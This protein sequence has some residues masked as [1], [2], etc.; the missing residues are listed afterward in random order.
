M[1]L[2]RRLS[3]CRRMNKQV[4]KSEKRQTLPLQ[5]SRVLRLPH[6]F[7][8]TG[9]QKQTKRS[10]GS[11]C[12]GPATN[13]SFRRRCVHDGLGNFD[14][15]CGANFVVIL[16]DKNGKQQ[17][18]EVCEGWRA[19]QQ[20]KDHGTAHTWACSKRGAAFGCVTSLLNKATAANTLSA[21]RNTE[22]H[23]GWSKVGFA[24]MAKCKPAIWDSVLGSF[25]PIHP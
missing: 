20:E 22:L 13:H 5:M 18:A 3:V 23:P 1:K 14:S 24:E 8:M 4:G 6:L 16:R 21:A 11:R 17:L 19:K 9:F 15:R 10:S 2:W 12:S 7:Q 25:T